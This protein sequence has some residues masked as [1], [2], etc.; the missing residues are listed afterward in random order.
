MIFTP[1]Q[2]N[3]LLTIIDRFT[4]YFIV[5]NIGVESLTT[6][7]KVELTNFGVDW[8]LFLGKE[9]QLKQMFRMGILSGI[10]GHE[11]TKQL[12]FSDFKKYIERGQFLPMTNAEEEAFKLIEHQAYFDTKKQGN[13][14]KEVLTN[15][16]LGV[17]NKYRVEFESQVLTAAQKNLKQRESITEMVLDLGNKTGDWSRDFLRIS[18]Y[19]MHTAFEEGKAASFKSLENPDPLVYKD[20]FG[21]ACRHCIK[22][23]LSGGLGSKPR[24]FRLSELLANGTNIG[25]KQA[26]WKP[27]VGSQHPYCRCSL[28]TLPLNYDWSEETRSFSLVTHYQRK[29]ERQSKVK[30]V[31]GDKVF[32]R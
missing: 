23:Y 29:V 17:S 22:A 2:I 12:E 13:R 8:K 28:R 21:G 9:S 18:D 16:H 20:V 25:R 5:S 15:T 26:E 14:V 19:V 3:E 27:V 31:I 1:N 11:A 24:V 10:L 7:D 6:E 30:I 32:E 4:L